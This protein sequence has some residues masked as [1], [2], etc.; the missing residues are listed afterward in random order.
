M[1]Q[2]GGVV[3]INHTGSKYYMVPAALSKRPYSRLQAKQA[4]EL[5]IRQEARNIAYKKG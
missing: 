2:N 5:M 4:L 3:L 1:Q